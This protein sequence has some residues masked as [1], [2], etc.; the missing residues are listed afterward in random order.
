MRADFEERER[1]SG[2]ESALLLR[3]ALRYVGPLRGRF[4]I[5]L[6]LVVVSLLPFLLLPWPVKIVIDHVIEA[7]PIGQA[8]TPYPFFVRPL[9]APLAGA[10]P[11]TI[12]F[13]TI[14]AQTLLLLLIGAIG[15]GGQLFVYE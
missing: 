6:G 5:K 11:E 10:T 9:L 1:I 3:R 7:T 8:V 15:A 2:R 13:W 4:V 14:G 12:L